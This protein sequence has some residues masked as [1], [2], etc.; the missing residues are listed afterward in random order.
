MRSCIVDILK[1]KEPTRCDKSHPP[2]IYP[3]HETT[4]THTH[5]QRTTPA[6]RHI[7]DKLYSLNHYTATHHTITPEFTTL[8][9]FPGMATKS[10]SYWLYSWWW[11]YWCPKHVEA[12]KLHISSH[13]VGSLPFSKQENK[14]K[15]LGYF[16][17]C[18]RQ[19]DL[20]D[21]LRSS[22]FNTYFNIILSPTPRPLKWPT[23]LWPQR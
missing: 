14:N 5:N 12:I 10:G 18:L 22:L 20:A 21:I 7:T 17:A 3:I 6:C 16:G 13:L 15:C 23:S 4:P 1:G 9:I 2:R 11:A 8:H 19:V